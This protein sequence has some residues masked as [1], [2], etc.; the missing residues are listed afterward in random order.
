MPDATGAVSGLLSTS[1][2]VTA[3]EFVAS[4][5]SVAF[6]KGDDPTTLVAVPAAKPPRSFGGVGI[7]AG[8]G[9]TRG[10]ADALPWVGALR[11]DLYAADGTWCES[12]ELPTP[13][14]AEPKATITVAKVRGMPAMMTSEKAIRRS[15]SNPHTLGS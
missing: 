11:V 3:R 15:F 14:P 8:L 1:R 13:S 9:V 12:R 5:S 2:D 7:A 10:A 6:I 4:E